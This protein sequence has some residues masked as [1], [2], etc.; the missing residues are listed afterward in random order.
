M[1]AKAYRVQ[2][3]RTTK[4]LEHPL[5]SLP[6]AKLYYSNKINRSISGSR[7]WFRRVFM[8][9]RACVR[10]R[11]PLKEFRTAGGTPDCRATPEELRSIRRAAVAGSG[12]LYMTS[13]TAA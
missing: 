11:G 4:S 8:S 12:D 7:L 13:F 2:A 10:G 3:R 9:N 6:V 5:G 1:L